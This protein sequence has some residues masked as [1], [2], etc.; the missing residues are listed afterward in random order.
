MLASEDRY[1]GPVQ[2]GSRNRFQSDTKSLPG[3]R[4]PKNVK[5]EGASGDVCEN[6]GSSETVSDEE[7]G[8]L[9][10]ATASR[11]NSARFPWFAQDK[12]AQNRSETANLLSDQPPDPQNAKNEGASGDMY[13]N[14]W[15][16]EIASDER[17]GSLQARPGQPGLA[18]TREHRRACQR[19]SN[20]RKSGLGSSA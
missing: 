20:R 17:S 5:N 18:G 6:K 4:Y 14:K 3:R 15:S 16:S 11:Q 10:K 19:P 2:R 1:D 9:H 13:E 12:L 8:S 7:S